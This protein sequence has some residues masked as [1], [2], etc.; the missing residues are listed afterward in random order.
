MVDVAKVKLYGET[1]GIFRWDGR[2]NIVQF[3]Y[4]KKF[5]GRGLEYKSSCP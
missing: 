2:S 1:I 5:I 4:E 3:E